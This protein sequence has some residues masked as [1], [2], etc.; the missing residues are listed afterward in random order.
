M[1]K[2]Y[3]TENKELIE[4]NNFIKESWISL[5]NPTKEEISKIVDKFNL[6]MDFVLDALD[7]NE[8]SRVSIEDG[9]TFVIIRVP[10]L[11][12]SD[13]AIPLSTTSLGIF[14]FDDNI[15]TIYK[16]TEFN[17]LKDLFNSKTNKIDT[18]DNLK[19]LLEIF[20]KTSVLY[21][22]YLKEIDEKMDKLENDFNGK[23]SNDGLSKLLNLE[24][25]LIYFK[26]GLNSNKVVLNKFKKFPAIKNSELYNDL[27]DDVVIENNQAMEISNIYSKVL[28]DMKN[29]FSSVMSNNLNNRMKNLT[30]VTISLMVPT[31]IT[32]FFGMNVNL[33]F[34][35]H[36]STAIFIFFSSIFV[37][38]VTLL[39]FR[40]K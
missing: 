31:L 13:V 20:R 19:F 27:L 15:M 11:D 38:V 29:Y 34:Q 40:K 2:I 23:A 39:L 6:P 3:K 28:D 35:E 17:I 9:K 16:N 1:L 26:T 8:R 4:K 24:R 10:A 12:I 18:K 21:L 32:S 30:I 37:T 14:I 5:V 36:D 25:S 7:M 22:R 33:P